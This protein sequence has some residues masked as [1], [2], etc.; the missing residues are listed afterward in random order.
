MTDERLGNGLLGVLR[1]YFEGEDM[2][3]T[4]TFKAANGRQVEVLAHL[5]HLAEKLTTGRGDGRLGKADAERLFEAISAEALYTDMH[6]KTIRHIRRHFRWTE[7]GNEH[8][9]R[10][11]RQAAG[12]GWAA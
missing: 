4:I 8:F 2:S 9:R 3:E 12:R 5:W 7:K 11:I 10:L 1:L 6:K